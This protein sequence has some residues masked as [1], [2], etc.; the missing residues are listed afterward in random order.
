LVP[1][2]SECFVLL[3][4]IENIKIKVHISVDI[5]QL[6]VSSKYKI[7]S[8]TFGSEQRYRVLQKYDIWD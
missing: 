5:I 4:D 8:L 3:F 6:V 1:F 2:G 7:C